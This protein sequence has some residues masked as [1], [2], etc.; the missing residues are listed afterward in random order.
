[1]ENFFTSDIF[2][3]KQELV[4]DEQI[5]AFYKALHK[6]GIKTGGGICSIIAV[7]KTYN[8]SLNKAL[9]KIKKYQLMSLEK[10]IIKYV[11]HNVNDYRHSVDFGFEYD[12]FWKKRI[13]QASNKK[14][15]CEKS[16]KALI[17]EFNYDLDA[18]VSGIDYNY[19]ANLVTFYQ[20]RGFESQK[21]TA[22]S[23]RNMASV[24]LIDGH[25]YQGFPQEWENKYKINVELV[26][27]SINVL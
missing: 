11:N 14:A 7:M 3:Q 20:K 21:A 5:K 23:R 27:K 13:I 1:M 25:I 12:N 22:K 24:K 17:K 6:V 19:K 4:N 16:V 15:L 9:Q 18:L 2:T 26:P 10:D 8:I